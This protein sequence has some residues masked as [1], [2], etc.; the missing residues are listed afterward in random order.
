MKT[1]DP[2]QPLLDANGADVLTDN[3]LGKN[4]FVHRCVTPGAR[5][6]IE[7]FALEV[8]NHL[9]KAKR[10]LE[11]KDPQDF[12]NSDELKKINYLISSMT[13][14]YIPIFS[15][16]ISDKK[17]ALGQIGGGFFTS[18]KFP[19]PRDH[20][21]E[22]LAPLVQLS[23]DKISK[24]TTIDV[25]SGLLQVWMASGT[26]GQCEETFCRVIPQKHFNKSESWPD[27]VE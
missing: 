3:E 27:E 7:K 22:P 18:K 4:T 26:W 24:Q 10:S 21:G 9:E 12:D 11:A 16:D 8:R 14:A 19:T 17:S 5:K 23:L 13:P 1:A 15:E 20:E 25:G 6:Q 2:V